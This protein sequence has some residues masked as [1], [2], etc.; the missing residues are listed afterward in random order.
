[1][2]PDGEKRSME[3]PK[4]ALLWGRRGLGTPVPKMCP[5]VGE[6]EHRDPKT[7]PGG[8]KSILGAPKID[9][10]VRRGP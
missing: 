10:N 5:S 6:E 7:C 9:P 1:M 3:T 2:H 4:C 8:G